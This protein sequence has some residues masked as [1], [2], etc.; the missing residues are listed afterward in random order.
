MKSV[1]RQL[2]IKLPNPENFQLIES[3]DE[4]H[5][6]FVDLLA[7]IQ[8]LD[9]VRD[10]QNSNAGTVWSASHSRTSGNNV[11]GKIRHWTDRRGYQ[12]ATIE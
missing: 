8:S 2:G 12:R 10:E 3:G 6:S 1:Y 5:K 7:R 4:L 9:F 11:L